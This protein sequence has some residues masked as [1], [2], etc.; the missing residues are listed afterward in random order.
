MARGR[1]GIGLMSGTSMDGVDAALCL[2]EGSG[3][4]ARLGLIRFRRT[5]YPRGLRERIRS[6][7]EGGTTAREI[8]RLHFEVGES[9]A[10]A[11]ERILAGTGLRP[12]FVGSHG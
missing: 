9:F 11:A 3:A 12:D 10:R 5:P 2:V 4:S 7:A 1:I 8:C 6:L